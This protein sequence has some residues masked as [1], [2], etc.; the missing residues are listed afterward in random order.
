[1]SVVLTEVGAGVMTITLADEENRNALDDQDATHLRL[2][3]L[4][5]KA[6]HEIAAC[7]GQDTSMPLRDQARERA[8]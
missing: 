1:M 7:K 3:E 2:L 4:R 6:I 8:G 5:M